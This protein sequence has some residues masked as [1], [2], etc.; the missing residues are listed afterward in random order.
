MVAGHAV[1]EL[2]VVV[3]V[4]RGLGGVMRRPR[5]T[6]TIAAAGGLTLLWLAWSMVRDGLA[7][8]VVTEGPPAGMSG[9]P[10][11][12][13]AAVSVSNPYWL[14]W[15]VTAGASYMAFSLARGPAG[16]GAFYVGH[17]LSDFAWYSAVAGAVVV[18]RGVMG[19]AVYNGVIVVAGLFLAGMAVLFL[20]SA[21]RPS[22][23]LAS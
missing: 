4:A 7:Q 17:V 16:L 11:L 12:I 6:R 3:A 8:R 21:V 14:L 19:P 10:V 2:I 20:R 22:G 15:W 5:V 1:L 13:G 23:Q 18:G 9:V